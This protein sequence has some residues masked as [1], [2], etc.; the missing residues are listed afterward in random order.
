MSK[1]IRKRATDAAYYGFHQGL[2]AWYVTFRP[3][4]RPIR[5]VLFG[6]GRSG[7]TALVSLL[8]QVPGI[9]C[10]GEVLCHRVARPRMHVDALCARSAA[11]CYG[12]KILSFH[13]SSLQPIE[14]GRDFVAQLAADGYRIIY[15][16]RDD[17]LRHALSNVHARA[18][19]FHEKKD[20]PAAA[21]KAMVV[22][23]EAV[24]RWMHGSLGLDA[25]EADLLEGVPHLSLT[26]E[27]DIQNESDHQNTVN[28]ICR[29]LG[30]QSH[31]VAC[32]YR[33]VTPPS[34]RELVANYD[35]LE[36]YLNTTALAPYVRGHVSTMATR[37]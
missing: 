28:R 23:P 2:C 19:R 9:Q 30:V 26:Y 27:R 24:S 15:L 21:R 29:Y 13:L 7:S 36:R 33:K 1:D 22:D 5:F 16:K 17:I 32:E 10:D 11:P 31:T 18:V 8:N 25:Y 4:L 6:R 12:C 14:S 20:V 3:P 35:E 34:I 37:S